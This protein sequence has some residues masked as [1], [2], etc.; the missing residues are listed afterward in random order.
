[1]PTGRM[2]T[3]RNNPGPFGSGSLEHLSTG[4]SR[5]TAVSQGRMVPHRWHAQRV[6]PSRIEEN[7]QTLD[8]RLP[9]EDMKQMSPWTAP[10]R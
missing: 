7:L 3:L 9:E 8:F 4:T 2:W 6:T 5:A 10:W 1:M